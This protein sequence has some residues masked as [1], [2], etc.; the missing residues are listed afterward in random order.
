MLPNTAAN[1]ARGVVGCV[2]SGGAITCPGA[3]SGGRSYGG[4]NA[5][6]MNMMSGL[7]GSLMNGIMTGIE[8]SAQ[9]ARARGYSLNDQG[10]AQYRA[11]EYALA[12]Q[13]FRQALQLVPDDANV[14]ENL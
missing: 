3:P 7:M 4:G 8:Q 14:R 9:Q 5:A 13:S 1:R 6:M 2:Q 10:I 11:G 12:A